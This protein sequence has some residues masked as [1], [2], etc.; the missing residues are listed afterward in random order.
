M[1]DQEV[2]A[3]EVLPESAQDQVESSDPDTS[4]EPEVKETVA[5][6]FTQE[7]LDDIVQRRV[8]KAESQAERRALRSMRE[9]LERQTV[10]PQ[11]AVQDK[12]PSRDQFANDEEWLDARDAHRDAKREA[13]ANAEKQSQT[14]AQLQTK[15]DK[16]YA[17]AEKIVGFDRDSFDELPITAPIASALVDSDVAPQLMAYLV[18]N[19]GE[20]DRISLLSAARQSAEIGKLEVKLQTAEV[21]TSKAPEPITPIG[22]GKSAV[23]SSDLSKLPMDQFIA[24]MAKR[25]S[26]YIR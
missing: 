3:V 19:P 25:G 13:Q 1:S 18:K 11:Q 2:Q 5:K 10:A 26:R 24:E 4:A 17:Q 7:E 9:N 20:V 15:T 21:R 8:A 12:P 23:V 22:G 16:I 6:V 14:Q